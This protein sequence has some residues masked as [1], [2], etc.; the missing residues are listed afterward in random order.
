VI[1][2][3]IRHLGG[4]IANLACRAFSVRMKAAKFSGVFVSAAGMVMPRAPTRVVNAS[5]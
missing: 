5:E 4:F 1:G 3:G 2:F